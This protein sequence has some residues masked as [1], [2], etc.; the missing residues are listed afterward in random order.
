MFAVA[1]ESGPARVEM[2]LANADR[3]EEGS[4]LALL[5]AGFA[6][7]SVLDGNLDAGQ[8]SWEPLLECLIIGR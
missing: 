8:G 3:A 5:S 1:G 6:T 2:A 7:I 4:D